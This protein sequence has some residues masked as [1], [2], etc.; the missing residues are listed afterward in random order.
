MT[1]IMQGLTRRLKR[2][3][4]NP[5]HFLQLLIPGTL[6]LLG[7]VALALDWRRVSFFLVSAAVIAF[8]GLLWLRLRKIHARID[9]VLRRAASLQSQVAGVKPI[10]QSGAVETVP[11]T[12]EDTEELFA[13]DEAERNWKDA[14]AL[15][16]SM[17]AGVPRG[18]FTAIEQAAPQRTDQA[19][20]IV[21]GSLPDVVANSIRV[22]D[23]AHWSIVAPGQTSGMLRTRAAGLDAV[24]IVDGDEPDLGSL[25]DQSFFWWLP[26]HARLFTVSDDPRGFAARL[27]VVHGVEFA[28]A[29]QW[30][31]ACRIVVTKARG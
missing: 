24:I 8:A 28:L 9:L 11:T 12:S 23:G 3:Q 1:R 15:T 18:L 2:L 17:A 25:L 31:G 14:V 26:S 29:E 13:H 5:R 10:L 27:A 7:W 20:M 16:L 22:L 30:P 21:P 4:K 19:L 6:V